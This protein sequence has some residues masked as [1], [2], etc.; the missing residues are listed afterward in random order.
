M[1]RKLAIAF[2]SFVVLTGATTFL[3]ACN[4]VEGAGKD[5][6]SAGTAITDEAKKDKN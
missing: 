1:R 6:S 5:V 3:S 2:I 4:T